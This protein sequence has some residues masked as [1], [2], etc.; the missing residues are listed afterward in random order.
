MANYKEAI[1][2]IHS[3]SRFGTKL[4][5]DNIS[6]LL[7]Y[8]GNPQKG[9]KIIHVAGTNGKG[10]TCSMIDS[11]LRDAGHRV[12]LFTSPYLETFNE[13]IKIDGTNITDY[14]IYNSIEKSN[15]LYR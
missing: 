10:S 12:G 5:L 4:G 11:I 2:Y 15:T 13:R 1:E 3:F 7:N 9:L 8:L 6:R 14:E